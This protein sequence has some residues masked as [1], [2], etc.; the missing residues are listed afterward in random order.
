MEKL[1]KKQKWHKR[2]CLL[3]L[4][5]PTFLTISL[6]LSLFLI[7]GGFLIHGFDQL[8]IF[9]AFFALVI[10]AGILQSFVVLLPFFILQFLAALSTFFEII[11]I[12]SCSNYKGYAYCSTFLYILLYIIMF[13]ALR[14]PIGI[15]SFGILP[16]INFLMTI[17][18]NSNY[19]KLD[20]I[21]KEKSVDI[22][23]VANKINNDSVDTSL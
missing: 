22:D 15:F 6:V 18:D 23:A 4:I 3:L 21:D 19:E 5:L 12:S 1:I 20:D 2:V 13:L 9:T 8:D 7:A 11:S 17:T 16:L 10:G 14:F